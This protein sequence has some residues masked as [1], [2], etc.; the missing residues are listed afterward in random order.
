MKQL[1]KKTIKP[2]VTLFTCVTALLLMGGHA[3]AAV[4]LNDNPVVPAVFANEID[5][6]ETNGTS[7]ANSGTL[8][9][10]DVLLGADLQADENVWLRFDITSAAA[11]KPVF[12]GT[13]SLLVHGDTSGTYITSGGGDGVSYVVFQVAGADAWTS[14]ETVALSM[15]SLG[16]GGGIKVYSKDPVTIQYRLYTT[17]GGDS[18]ATVNTTTPSG[19]AEYDTTA[20]SYV[21][22]DDAL[23][24][25]ITAGT[26]AQID[27][28]AS[29][30]AFVGPSDTTTLGQASLT[31][32]SNV[33]WTD[34]QVPAISDLFS[35]ARLVISGNI[36]SGSEITDS[37]P[38]NFTEN[39]SAGT[40]TLT[41][42]GAFPYN[43]GANIIYDLTNATSAA[44]ET[45]FTAQF[46]LTTATGVESAIATTHGTVTTLCSLTKNGVTKTVW[47]IPSPD[48]MAQ[49]YIRITNT[50]GVA[51]TIA[52]TLY[53]EA[54][55]I[56]WSGDI[57]GATGTP[58]AASIAAHQTLAVSNSD[59]AGLVDG[60]SNAFPTWSTGERYRLVLNSALPSM[61]VVNFISQNG[62]LVNASST[63]ADGV[64]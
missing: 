49:C 19:T 13:P 42:S 24:S 7:L 16:G 12:V 9:N 50:S 2:W 6:D 56:A 22:W 26:P 38:S 48:S 60:S 32:T 40:A 54:G 55:S 14:T 45:T 58:I 41:L 53:D 35:L 37:V 39:V 61:E 28:S 23:I 4:D 20:L 59:L 51:G 10:V 57:V 1:R 5:V 34:G 47:N 31:L 36:A 21:D 43:S 62:N 17:T 33:Y 52:G 64:E 30:L 44:Q 29:S 25:T 11:T 63:V 27:V 46:V 8:L 18:V 15:Q 3:L